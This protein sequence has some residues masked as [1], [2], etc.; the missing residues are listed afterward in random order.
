MQQQQPVISFEQMQKYTFAEFIMDKTVEYL[1]PTISC[2]ILQATEDLQARQNP[3]Y[4]R[5]LFCPAIRQQFMTYSLSTKWLYG[6]VFEPVFTSLVKLGQLY[7]DKD[8]ARYSIRR[9]DSSWLTWNEMMEQKYPG[10][11]LGAD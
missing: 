1:T 7:V 11:I 4:S 8:Y 6:D 2:L 9:L 10:Y 5:G 3:P